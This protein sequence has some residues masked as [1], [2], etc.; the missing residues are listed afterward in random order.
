MRDVQRGHFG[1][2]L[3]RDRAL[4]CQR[5]LVRLHGFKGLGLGISLSGCGKFAC[6]SGI[7]IWFWVYELS[8]WPC[9]VYQDV[10]HSLLTRAKYV[11][12]RFS[13]A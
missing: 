9:N 4:G 13:S 5:I 11:D 3:H 6:R 2:H 12:L 1:K 8:G 7:E 10:H